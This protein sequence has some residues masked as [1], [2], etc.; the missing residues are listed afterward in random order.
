MYKTSLNL[1]YRDLIQCEYLR[2]L[3]FLSYDFFILRIGQS[4]LY[5]LKPVKYLEIVLYNIWFNLNEVNR[6]TIIS[7]VTTQFRKIWRKN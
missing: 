7:Y 1:V 5:S 4:S 6:D 2:T 3:K